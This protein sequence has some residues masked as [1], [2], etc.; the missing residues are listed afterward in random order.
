MSTGKTRFELRKALPAYRMNEYVAEVSS[1][2]ILGALGE[3]RWRSWVWPLHSP[4]GLNVVQEFPFDHSFHNGIFVGQGKVAIRGR[5]SHFWAPVWPWGESEN[6]VYNDI[7]TLDFGELPVSEADDYGASFRYRRIVWRDHEGRP[8]I[9]EA[10]SIEIRDIGDATTCDV[11]T[12]KSSTYGEVVYGRTKHGVIGVRVQPQLLPPFGA[13]I[14]GCLDGTMTRGNESD[15]TLKTWDWIAYEADVDGLGRHGVCMIPRSNSAADDIRGPW[16]IR[17]YGMAM[18]NPT[19]HADITVPKGITWTVA[20]R[21]VAY[22]GAITPG[23]V[24][25]WNAE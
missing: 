11:T 12:A 21:V 6:Y 7:G 16:F 1:N 15:V 18:F 2:R 9:D 3:N 14:V 20:E 10:R 25:N 19:Y 22:D 8:L 23:R 4:R 5:E 13:D 24:A 17:D